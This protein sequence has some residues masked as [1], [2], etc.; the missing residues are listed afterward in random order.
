M[1]YTSSSKKPIVIASI[2]FLLILLGLA[3]WLLFTPPGLDGKLAAVGYSVCH[4]NH[5]HSIQIGGRVLPVCARCL[6]MFTGSLLGVALLQFHRKPA[7]NP[8]R[9][10][11]PV[12]GAFVVFFAIDGINSV[13]YSLL[14]G[15]SL[16]VPSNELRLISG[17]CMGLTI[18]NLLVPIWRQTVRS[19][20]ENEAVLATW[21]QLLWMVAGA[22][23]VTLVVLYAPQWMYYPIA[24]LS[25][26]AIPILVTMVYTLLWI[27]LLKKENLISNWS[28]KI[29]YIMLGCLSAFIQIGLLDLIRFALTKTWM[30]IRF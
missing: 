4:Q 18:A 27:L 13:L 17:L 30:G 23:M 26:T 20:W 25:I 19:K 22:V 2:L 6:G 28:V 5:G 11:W 7:A 16:Y 1:D 9:K 3:A 15:K 21:R 8:G 14:G 29:S 12:L 10:F 24:I